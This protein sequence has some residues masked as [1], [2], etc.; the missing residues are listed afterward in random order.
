MSKPDETSGHKPTYF[1]FL[2]RDKHETD[3]SSITGAVVRSKLPAEKAGYAV[4]REGHGND[5]DKLV[6]DADGFSLEPPPHFY[7]VPPANFGQ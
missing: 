3:S 6:N 5:P 1:F 4:Y 2:D 7:S